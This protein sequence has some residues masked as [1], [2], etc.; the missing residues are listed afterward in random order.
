MWLMTT[1]GR[2][3]AAQAVIEQ[4]LATHMR[5]PAIM[6]VDKDPKGY[7]FTLPDN[8][9]KVEGT[10]NLAGSKR[11]VFENF[12]DERTYGWM[13]DDNWPLTPYWSY[14]VEDMADPWYLVHCRD[15]W[16]SDQDRN[17]LHETRN[18]GG[19]ICWGG[20]LV[21]AVGWWAPPKITQASI[22]WAWTSLVGKTCLGVYLHN[23]I[24]RHDNWDSG[25]R[26]KDKTDEWGDHMKPDIATI[27]A[28]IESDNFIHTQERIIREYQEYITGE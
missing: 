25:R 16:I 13:A 9:T 18:L 12:P 20:E 22:D 28:W 7:D 17:A 14:I 2:P 4:C 3:L 8:W 24:V 5:Q 1:K 27:R 21:R 26:M 23:V 6:Y 19:G 11:Y 15:N 10:G